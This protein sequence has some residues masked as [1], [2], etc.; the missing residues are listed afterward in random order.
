MTT[1]TP[2]HRPVD[3][4][5]NSAIACYSDSQSIIN[6]LRSYIH[7]FDSILIPGMAVDSNLVIVAGIDPKYYWW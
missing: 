4:S 5:N 7:L 6:I 2:L 1:M 3:D